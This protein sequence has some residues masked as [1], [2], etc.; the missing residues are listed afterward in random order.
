[1]RASLTRTYAFDAAHRLPGVPRGHKCG[2]MHGHGYVLEVTVA[3]PV[4]RRTGWVV[5]FA[6]LDAA[7]EPLVAALDH[8]TLNEVAGLE[9]PTS[10]VLARWFWDRLRPRLRGL[11]EV[12]IAESPRSRCAVRGR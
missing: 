3:G 7:A 8:R 9:N 12:A 11:R 6:D 1:V 4:G 2:R 5:D 10:E